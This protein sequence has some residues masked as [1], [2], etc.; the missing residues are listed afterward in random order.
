VSHWPLQ[1]VMAGDLA[2]SAPG[3]A[4]HTEDAML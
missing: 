1:A 3:E 2:A 4:P